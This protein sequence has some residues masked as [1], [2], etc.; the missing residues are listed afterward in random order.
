MKKLVKLGMIGAGIVAALVLLALGVFVLTFDVNDYKGT[1]S[2]IVAQRTGR[3]LT[4]G[5][6]ISL[7]FL[8]RLGVRMADVALG[9]APGFGP[10]P[11]LAVREARLEVRLLPLFSGRVRFGHLGLDGAVVNL[12]RDATGRANWD[13][14]TDRA[15][16]PPDPAS[17]NGAPQSGEAA[18][19]SF[20]LDIEGVRVTDAT[21]AWDDRRADTAV[22]LHGLSLTTGTIG[23]GEPFPV[24]AR[25][26]VRSA[27]P[28]VAGEIDLEARVTLA[29]G[30]LTFSDVTIRAHGT[31]A[32]VPGTSASLSAQAAGGAVD[33]RGDTVRVDGLAV[34][35]YGVTARASGSLAGFGSDGRL[36]AT[37]GL[38]RFDARQTL[39]A[40]GLAVPDMADPATLTRV[41]ATAA[42]VI[43]AQGFDARQIEARIDDTTVS[44]S[45]S[46][47]DDGRGQV[48]TVRLALDTLDLD[49]YL[50]GRKPAPGKAPAGVSP[51]PDAPDAPGDSDRL[52]D[53][54]M[55]R[56]LSLDLHA[57]ADHLRAGGARLTDVVATVTARDGLVRLSPLKAT[58]YGGNLAVG[59]TVN[60]TG[61]H[62]ATDLIVGVDRVDVGA[63]SRD[64]LGSEEYQGALSLNCALACRGAGRAAM[65]RSLGGRVSLALADGVFPGVDLMGMARTTHERRG[66]SEGTVEAA[67]TDA[68]R[69]GSI[70]ATG[71]ITDG[72]L[73]TRDLEVKA[74]GLRADGLG[75]V[76]LPTGTIDSLIKVKLVPTAKGQGGKASADLY[77]VMV[78]IRVTGTLDAPR[79]RVSIAEYVKAL[80]GAV[81]D[82]AGSVLHGVTGIV[83]GVGK[84]ITGGGD[85]ATEGSE[86]KKRGFFDLF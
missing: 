76:N 23:G 51:R 50:P 27:A 12:R 71:V 47:R 35:G 32:G 41:E 53:A 40:L 1:V 56:G 25:C 4:F 22:T 86:P 37:V 43:E 68:T 54:A 62:P 38:D 10:A 79:Y 67:S 82:T 75:S 72:V 33:L 64:V 26:D 14:L 57:S 60:V 83:R 80:G 85:N 66:R 39:A 3:E 29:P 77:G 84:A 28:E 70:T 5:G 48:H 17:D 63:L 61:E 65:L 42:L 78:P 8:P 46:R 15:E 19:G 16:A 30:A 55:L 45:L 20:T 52:I 24:A 44:G 18:S 73:T 13:D 69:F 9:D 7:A 59:V 11:M 2:R 34:T 74:P 36:T 31:G 58:L 49:R 21:L 6:D 81:L